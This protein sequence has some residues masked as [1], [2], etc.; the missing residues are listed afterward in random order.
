MNS[1]QVPLI[2]LALLAAVIIVALLI[3]RRVRTK[4]KGPFGTRLDLDASNAGIDAKRMTS[5]EAGFGLTIVQ[6]AASE[7]IG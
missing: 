3:N 1:N 7:P 2:A 6:E 5:Q 4:L